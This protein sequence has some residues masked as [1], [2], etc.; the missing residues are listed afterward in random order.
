VKLT[1][2]SVCDVVELVESVEVDEGTMRVKVTTDGVELELGLNGLEAWPGHKKSTK[3]PSSA[4]PSTE[5]EGTSAPP[6][7]ATSVSST[8]VRLLTHA[9]EQVFP[10]VKS[11]VEQLRSW[12]L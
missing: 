7:T 9:V 11:A 5:L 10:W 1:T 12:P 3:L 6:H 2:S 4:C 8:L